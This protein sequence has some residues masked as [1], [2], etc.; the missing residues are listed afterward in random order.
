MQKRHIANH[1]YQLGNVLLDIQQHSPAAA[2][3]ASR[4]RPSRTSAMSMIFISLE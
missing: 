3:S 2:R 4:S 1:E